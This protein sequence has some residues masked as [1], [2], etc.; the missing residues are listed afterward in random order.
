M[1]GYWQF[2]QGGYRWVAGFWRVPASEAPQRAV[3]AAPR[4][5]PPP[6]PRAADVETSRGRWHWDGR[7]YLWID[8]GWIIRGGR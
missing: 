3:A 7:I 6:T 4:P 5:P 8:G 1:P 2:D